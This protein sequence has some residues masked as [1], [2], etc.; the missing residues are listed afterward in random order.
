MILIS[1]LV[2]SHLP[3]SAASPLPPSASPTVANKKKSSRS[4]PASNAKAAG[5]S[6]L[7]STSCMRSGAGPT[8][9]QKCL[10][11]TAQTPHPA[12]ISNPARQACRRYH[13]SPH[14]P[15]K[16]LRVVLSTHCIGMRTFPIQ[17][18]LTRTSMSRLLCRLLRRH[19]LNSI[20][21]AT[22]G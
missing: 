16:G 5:A 7:S 18:R 12:S 1:S 8:R 11:Q 22:M 2:A 20:K 3:R 21:G 6:S 14:R 9:I 10:T 15:R 4:S 13:S 17:T 19:H